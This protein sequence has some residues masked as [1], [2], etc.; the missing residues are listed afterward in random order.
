[1]PPLKMSSYETCACFACMYCMY[2][3]IHT[4]IHVLVHALAACNISAT[5]AS[6]TDNICPL[7]PWIL[8]NFLVLLL[9]LLLVATFVK[10]PNGELSIWEYLII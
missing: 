5:W 2:K 8:G 4:N 3:Y 6:R 10:S 7:P 1:M 9:P